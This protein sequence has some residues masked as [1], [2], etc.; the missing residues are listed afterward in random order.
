MTQL[1][2]ESRASIDREDIFIW[3]SRHAGCQVAIA[4]DDKLSRMAAILID[5]PQ[6]GGV[7]GK[8]QNQRKLVVPHFPFILVYLLVNDEVRIL[9]VL[10]TSR[11]LTSRWLAR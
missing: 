6:A 7:A 5:N 8:A 4:A 1:R 9:R 11:R 2:W 10:H 3:L